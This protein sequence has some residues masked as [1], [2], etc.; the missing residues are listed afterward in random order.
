[1]GSSVGQTHV[2]Q[3]AAALWVCRQTAKS[4]KLETTAVFALLFF[5][6]QYLR[7]T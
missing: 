2:C 3:R 4:L 7:A 5:A 6:D 1:M